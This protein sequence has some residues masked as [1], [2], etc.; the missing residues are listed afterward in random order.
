MSRVIARYLCIFFFAVAVLSLIAFFAIVFLPPSQER[1]GLV[2]DNFSI[3][4][5]KIYEGDIKSGS[6]FIRNVSDTPVKIVNVIASCGCTKWKLDKKDIAPGD[7]VFLSLEFDSAGRKGKLFLPA[8]INYEMINHANKDEKVLF[9][10]PVEMIVEVIPDYECTPEEV[11]FDSHTYQKKQ[12]QISPVGC[13]TIDLKEV[14]LSKPFFEVE[15]IA[16]NE[17]KNRYLEISFFPD[18]YEPDSG[19]SILKVDA[20]TDQNKESQ[21]LIRLIVN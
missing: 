14:V 19:K 13:G 15:M 11:I 1:K 2:V 21:I 12:I 3:D 17:E 10:L 6:F 16:S 20:I 9:H 18:K 5:G 4:I 8:T 7:S